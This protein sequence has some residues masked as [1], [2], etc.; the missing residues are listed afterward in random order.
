MT[1]ESM[2]LLAAGLTTNLIV[3]AWTVRGM[4]ARTSERIATLEGKSTAEHIAVQT[5]LVDLKNEIVRL[6]DARHNETGQIQRHEGSIRDLERRVG[7]LEH[8]N[9]VTA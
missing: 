3:V 9:E 5:A 7:R 2:L 8:T 6:R 1:L 4:G